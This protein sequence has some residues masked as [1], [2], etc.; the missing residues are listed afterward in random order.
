M[1]KQYPCPYCE[2]MNYHNNYY[3][4]MCDSCRYQPCPHCNQPMP[5]P[6]RKHRRL[7]NN[8]YE[9]NVYMK[10]IND[11]EEYDYTQLYDYGP[12]PFVIN[13]EDATEQNQT[14]RTALWTGEHLQ[15]TLMSIPVG[16]DI[17]LE[18]HPNIDQFIR[19]EDGE[20]IIYMGDSSDYFDFQEMVHEDDI[21]IVPANKWHN[22]VN[23]GEVPILL[24]SIYAPPKHPH[25]T[26]QETKADA[27]K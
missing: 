15:L 19:I 3:Y 12:E 7:Y 17:G 27:M 22:L 20:G 1:R 21:I 9:P 4:D 2:Y 24:Y 14:F 6:R 11:E 23:T 5:R 10:Q 26:V 25:G 16:E 18:I 13:I 8:S